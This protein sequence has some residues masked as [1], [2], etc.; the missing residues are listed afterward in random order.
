MGPTPSD[1]ELPGTQ[2]YTSTKL[3]METEARRVADQRADQMQEQMDDMKRQMAEMRQMLLEQQVTN[4][5]SRH[6]SN[7]PQRVII[8]VN[9]ML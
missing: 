3:Q 4:S 8:L 7:T 5:I 6:V 9:C 1:L 2:K